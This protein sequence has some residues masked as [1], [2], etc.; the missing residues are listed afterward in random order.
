M[1]VEAEIWTVARTDKGNAV[2]VKPLESERAVPIFIGQLE[3]QSILIGLGKVPMPRPL[4]HDLFLTVLEQLQVKIERVE[5]TEL[6]DGTFYAKIQ[7]RQEG[8]ELS[9]DSRPS[10]ALGLAARLHCPVFIS[11]S[12][13]EEAGIEINL[14]TE[15]ESQLTVTE[16]VQD[17]ERGKLE[18][19]LTKAIEDENYEEAARIRDRLNQMQ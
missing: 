13:V 3:A 1:L 16:T 11:D 15:D 14:I 8:R 5:I 2:L 7:M 17:S 9:I 18:E 4:T 10:D 12:V 19:E 6:K